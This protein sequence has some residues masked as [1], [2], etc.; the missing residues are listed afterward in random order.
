MPGPEGFP[1]IFPQ[2][3]AGLAVVWPILV[4]PLGAGVLW[5]LFERWY[6]PLLQ[7]MADRHWA[8]AFPEFRDGDV[9]KTKQPPTN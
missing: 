2:G 5:V 9:D 6:I 3:I 7:R 1:T 8:K 4:L